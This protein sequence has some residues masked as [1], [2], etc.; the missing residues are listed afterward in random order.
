M[1]T[2]FSMTR[3]L[4]CGLL[5][6]STYLS[7]AESGGSA[8]CIGGTLA[9]TAGLKGRIVTTDENA[10]IFVAKNQTTRI[11]W[12]KIN[13]IEYGQNVSR[14]VMLAWMVSPMF[15]LTKSR[16]HYVTLGFVDESGKQ[17]AIVLRVDKG[18]VRST[19]ATL[20]AR[21][22]RLVEYQDADARKSRHG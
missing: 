17:Q 18:I 10:F 9:G 3:Y 22:G 14:R 19:L 4:L 7:A 8:R 21:T 12:G 16:A 15:L 11:P 20:E 6:V 2:D 5:L 1:S 13:L